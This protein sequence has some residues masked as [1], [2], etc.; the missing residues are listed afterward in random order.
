MHDDLELPIRYKRAR[1]RL[2]GEPVG[3]CFKIYKTPAL[4][5]SGIDYGGGN[6][7]EILHRNGKYAVVRVKGSRQ[8]AQ[9]GATKY[10][11]ST[12]YLIELTFDKTSGIGVDWYKFY[13][14]KDIDPGNYWQQALKTLKAECDELA[15]ADRRGGP[16]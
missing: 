4:D 5:V 8:W 1:L 7:P 11:G 2:P 12:Y 3:R 13:E 16:T 6:N 14:L 10:Y 15:E 9:V